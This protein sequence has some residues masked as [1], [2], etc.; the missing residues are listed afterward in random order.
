M[1]HLDLSV[2]TSVV[3]HLEKIDCKP[4]LGMK[5]INMKICF[6]TEGYNEGSGGNNVLEWYEEGT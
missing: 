3:E 1:T 4:Y 6:Q 2:N 5:N